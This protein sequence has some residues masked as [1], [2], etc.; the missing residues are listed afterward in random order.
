MNFKKWL[1]EGEY[2][3]SAY[4]P[5][6]AM[7]Q[8]SSNFQDMNSDQEYG[9]RGIGSKYQSVEKRKRKPTYP[10]NGVLPPDSTFGS[11][12]G[13]KLRRGVETAAV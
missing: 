3:T 6:G 12:S 2:G 8:G 11:F 5:V 9:S 4:G 13:Q 10:K 1:L 7:A